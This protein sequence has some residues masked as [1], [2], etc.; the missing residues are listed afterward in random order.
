MTKREGLDVGGGHLPLEIISKGLTKFYMGRH[1][2]WQ[3][4]TVYNT[5]DLTSG[6]ET[7]LYGFT[8]KYNE[9]RCSISRRLVARL[10]PGRG[11]AEKAKHEFNVV[12]RL[13]ETRYPVP[14]IH[15]VEIDPE[16]LGAP[17]IT[18]DFIEGHS[19][20]EDFRGTTIKELEP[21]LKVFASLFLELHR[22]DPAMIFPELPRFVD[23]SDY[24]DFAL[25][26]ARRSLEK[27]GPSWLESVLDWLENNK[28][29]VSHGPLSVLHRDFH[30]ANIM[31]KP[32]GAHAIIDWT[33]SS[34]GDFREDLMW[35]FLLASAFWGRPLGESILGAYQRAA[36]KKVRDAGF[37]EVAA[38]YRRIQDTSISFLKGAEEASM[39]AGAVEQMREGLAHL[40]KVHDFL[41]ERTGIRLP[42]F[43]NILR[44]AKG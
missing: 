43:D 6:W 22:V 31:V 1:P 29:R 34:Y 12:R 15:D 33:A 3:Q 24:L 18:M 5:V 25:K 11:A 14:A 27:H 42:E 19:M 7:E 35:T 36:G 39:R 16:V 17:F 37:F 2:N 9:D 28:R 38:I 10:Y 40:Y 30:P 26:R 41:E 21:H 8:L 13:S 32:D 4:V 23:T 44:T 20:L